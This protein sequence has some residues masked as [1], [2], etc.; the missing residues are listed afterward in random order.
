MPSDFDQYRGR[1]IDNI[2][3]PG[4][5]KTFSLTTRTTH[6]SAE[7]CLTD[8]LAPT[9]V[10]M[11]DQDPDFRD[12]K[13]EANWVANVVHGEGVMIPEAGH[14]PHAQRPDVVIEA[15]LGFLGSHSQ[16]RA[17]TVPI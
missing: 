12:P 3:R 7:A 4:H 5:A 13:A 17:T 2:R 11:R 6:A 14:Y 8:V 10:L 1:V 15:V 16:G 9:L